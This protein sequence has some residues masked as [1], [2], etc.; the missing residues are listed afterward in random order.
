MPKL[1]GI[2]HR[3]A[4]RAFEQIGFVILREGKHIVMGRDHD[5][6]IIPRHLN[7]LTMGDIVRQAGLTT[8][9]SRRCCEVIGTAQEA[10]GTTHGQGPSPLAVS[11]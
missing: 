2:R 7:A 8:D 5:R 1:A 4:V 9:A 6:P 10:P 11:L 3:D